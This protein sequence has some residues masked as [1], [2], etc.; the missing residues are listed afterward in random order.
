MIFLSFLSFLTGNGYYVPEKNICVA[1]FPFWSL[2]IV[3]FGDVCIIV[4]L[5][6]LFTR[7]L[8][9]LSLPSHPNNEQSESTELSVTSDKN[10]SGSTIAIP[11]DKLVMKSL[12]EDREMLQLMKRLA[13]LTLIALFTTFTSLV[14]IALFE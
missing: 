2:G 6:I 14:F 12:H 3:A 11:K 4:I 9:L 10:K 1:N 5:S 8:M 7:R 13:L